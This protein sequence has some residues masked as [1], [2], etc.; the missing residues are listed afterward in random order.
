MVAKLS[1]L[2]RQTTS[3]TLTESSTGRV[4]THP[5]FLQDEFK[6]S[7]DV[8]INLSGETIYDR[9][10]ALNR[11]VD[12]EFGHHYNSRPCYGEHTAGLPRTGGKEFV[13]GK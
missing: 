6:W 11:D 4:T 3:L 8:M 1:F 12:Q 10:S 13:P 2:N 9:S 7:S 5:E